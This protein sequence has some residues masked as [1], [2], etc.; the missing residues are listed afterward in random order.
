MSKYI[1]IEGLEGAGKSTAMK[2]IK[3]HYA[4]KYPE[5][6]ITNVREPGGTILAEKMRNLVK[7]ECEGEVITPKTETFL[8]FGAREQLLVN[9][10]Q[11][12]LEKG[13][14]V[15]SDR[16]YLSSIAYQR[17]EQNLVRNLCNEL[18][19]KPDLIIYMDLDPRIGM[20]RARGRGAL[21][22]IEQQNISFFDEAREIYQAEAKSNKNILT[23]DA[24][25]SIDEVYNSIRK[26]LVEYDKS[27]ENKKK[28]KR[29]VRP[30]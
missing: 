6:K 2:A 4:E 8:F 21:D 29:R 7:E 10:V 16:C 18:T 23:I 25:K 15:L 5:D 11:P 26:T 19:H 22:R 3:D 30:H 27:L 17:K 28:Q 12:A 13:N 20:E 1:A 14:L 9:V 24:S